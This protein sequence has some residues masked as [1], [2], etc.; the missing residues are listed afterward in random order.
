MAKPLSSSAQKVQSALSEKGLPFRV[1]ELAASARSAEEA[2]QAIGCDVAQIVKS[3]VFRT[4]KT[5]RPVL[6]LVSGKNRVDEKK[7]RIL[8][9]EKIGKADA[10]FVRAQSG[11]AIGGVPPVGH[12]RPLVTLIDE[13]LLGHRELWAAAG[14][15]HAV[16]ALQ[17]EALRQLGRVADIKVKAGSETSAD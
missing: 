10:A 12:V 6:V 16:F 9:D 5:A 2:A 8:L 17:P 4:K 3:L 13:D 11:F 7:L 1:V 15:P 14:T